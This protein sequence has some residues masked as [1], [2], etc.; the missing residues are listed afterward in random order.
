MVLFLLSR[1]NR[2]R[3]KVFG[4]ILI[5]KFAFLGYKNI[6]S[7]KSTPNLHLSKWVSP[8][9]VKNQKILRL[10][11]RQNRLQKKHLVMF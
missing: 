2:L 8:W 11:L 1:Q 9:L 4:N 5:S 6:D 3:K 7:Q 10:L